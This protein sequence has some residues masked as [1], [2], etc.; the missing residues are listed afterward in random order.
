[1][2]PN[3]Y[4]PLEIVIK[5][6]EEF[7]YKLVLLSGATTANCVKISTTTCPGAPHKVQEMDSLLQIIEYVLRKV[8]HP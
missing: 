3:T 4:K 1:M 5:Q 2:G 6:I 8:S 7:R